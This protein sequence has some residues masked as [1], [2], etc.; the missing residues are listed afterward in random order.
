MD[1]VRA[2]T[3]AEAQR[4]LEQYVLP[5]FDP[6][7]TNASLC[8]NPNKVAEVVAD[9]AALGRTLVVVDSLDAAFPDGEAAAVTK[10]AAAAASEEEEPCLAAT[11][12]AK[13]AQPQGTEEVHC[14]SLHVA[15]ERVLLLRRWSR[16]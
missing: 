12:Q 14:P 9:F 8:C 2:V 1:A 7:R 13:G 10:P 3:Q 5:L 15:L 11:L 4:A 6:A 16:G